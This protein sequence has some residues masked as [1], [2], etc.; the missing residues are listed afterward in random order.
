MGLPHGL[1]MVAATLCLGAEPAGLIPSPMS[2][3][4]KNM[5]VWYEVDPG[6]PQPRPAAVEWGR[7]PGV[8]VDRQDQVWLF[9]RANPPVQVYTRDGKYVRGWGNEHI[10][11]SHGLRLDAQGHVWT[12][13]TANHVVMEFTPQGKPLRTLGTR[14]V[15]GEDAAHFDKP[16]DVAITPEGEL[17]VADGYGNNRI[18][19]F[20]RQGRFVK[21]WGRLGTAP[22]EFNL[23]HAIVADS[24]GRLYVADRSNAR[25]QVFDPQGKFLAEWRNLMVPWGLTITANDEIW[26]CGCSPMTWRKDDRH[27]SC[28]PKD[29]LLVRFDTSGR[30]L[31]LWTLPLGAEGKERPGE[32]NWLHGVAVDSRGDLYVTDIIGQRAQKLLRRE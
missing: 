21:S 10:G 17:Y 20:D 18:V 25:V 2:S 4:R 3:L 27:L 13:D 29:Q 23:P 6:W 22:G 24:R 15:P 30:A 31:Q 7:M 1:V 32:L 9:T 28:P 16:T 11:T 19:H 12:T 8:V 26:A 5:T 14:G